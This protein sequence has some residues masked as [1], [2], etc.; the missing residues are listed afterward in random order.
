MIVPRAPKNDDEARYYL[1]PLQ[2]STCGFWPP[3]SIR[4]SGCLAHLIRV[5]ALGILP[6][7]TE[8]IPKNWWREKTGLLLLHASIK[9]AAKLGDGKGS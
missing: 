2:A 4:S 7:C 8:W 1:F 9:E 3:P 6:G 5:V